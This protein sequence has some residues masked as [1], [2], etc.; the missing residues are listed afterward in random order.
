M[1]IAVSD[2]H[3]SS[4]APHDRK[5]KIKNK[6]QKQTN[7]IKNQT[8]TS[9]GLY[10]WSGVA[11][12]LCGVRLELLACVCASERSSERERTKPEEIDEC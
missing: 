9:K 10:A 12:R 4:I 8:E 2:K 3:Q 1:T 11:D 6:K 5:S 7:K